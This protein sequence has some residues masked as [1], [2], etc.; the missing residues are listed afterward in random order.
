MAPRDNNT[1]QRGIREPAAADTA[2]GMD[3]LRIA[4]GRPLHGTIRIG[5]A[6]NAALPLMAASL[7]TDDTLARSVTCRTLQTSRRSPICWS[8]TASI[9][10]CRAMAANG[11]AVSYR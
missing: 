9:S 5:G 11:W 8:N 4:G 10:P 1:Q 7:L 6:K 2:G 3:L